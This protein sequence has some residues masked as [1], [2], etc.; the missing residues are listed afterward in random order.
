MLKATLCLLLL[1]ASQSLYAVE[2]VRVFANPNKSYTTGSQVLQADQLYVLSTEKPCH[3]QIADKRNIFYFVQLPASSSM[4]RGCWYPTLDDGYVIIYGNGELS[5]QPLWKALPRGN[6]NT[7][8]T[9]TITET[10]YD[11]ATFTQNA[12]RNQVNEQLKKRKS[13]DF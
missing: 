13:G 6:L 10:D 8:G 1:I 12:L 3:L 7:D 2:R 5:K 4:R 11:S 9:I